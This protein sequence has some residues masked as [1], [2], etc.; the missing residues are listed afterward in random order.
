[1]EQLGCILGICE[2]G[3]GQARTNGDF[4]R[5]LNVGNSDGACYQFPKDRCDSLVGFALS[6]AP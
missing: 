3:D 6:T 1:M 2:S 4:E 5:D